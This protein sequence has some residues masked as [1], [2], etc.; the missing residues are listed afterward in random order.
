MKKLLVTLWILVFLLVLVGCGEAENAVPTTAAHTMTETESTAEA[1]TT[2]A[3]TTE[4]ETT[5]PPIDPPKEIPQ[6]PQTGKSLDAFIPEDYYL[7]S[8]VSL[9]FNADGREDYVG[10]LA[11][12][13]VLQTAYGC[14]W[15]DWENRANCTACARILFAIRNTGN[16]YRLSFQD[17]QLIMRVGEGGRFGSGFDRLI[18]NGRTFTIEMTM[19]SAWSGTDECTFQYR[20][21]TWYLVRRYQYGWHS[22]QGIATD[23]SIDDYLT[24]VGIRRKNSDERV[25][26]ERDPDAGPEVLR[27]FETDE[28]IKLGPPPTLKAF[29]KEFAQEKR[30][31]R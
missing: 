26:A 31:L 23:E 15:C 19:G 14:S 8:S 21:G 25:M 22:T 4:P 24:G 9:D 30:G 18:T 11:H 10:A 5:V 12:P 3:T 17:E 6:L 16:G 27:D 29:S 13:S 2:I 1:A 28:R 7:L 20:N